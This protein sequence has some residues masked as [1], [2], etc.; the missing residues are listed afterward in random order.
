M[1]I[2]FQCP[3]CA[4]VLKVPDSMAGRKGKC[5]RCGTV[6]T[7]PPAGQIQAEAP[8]PRPAARKSRGADPEVLEPDEMVEEDEEE[9][10]PLARKRA[11]NVAK[12][13]EDDA[14]EAREVRKRSK[15]RGKKKDKKRSPL[16]LYGLLGGFALL[17]FCSA[18][19]V[20]GWWLFA[21]RSVID[22][23]KFMP[24]HCQVLATIHMDELLQSGAFKELRR[25]IPEI[26]QALTQDKNKEMGLAAEDVEKMVIGGSTM[27][28]DET[29]TVVRTKKPVYAPDLRTGMKRT[30][31]TETKIGK[32]LLQEP[33]DSSSPAFC[34]PDKKVVIV[35]KT[36]ALR[37][38]LK[39]DK[40]PV[41]SE[42]LLAA[43]KQVD[44]SKTIA[45]AM[46]ARTGQS[47]PGAPPAAPFLG[48][49]PLLAQGFDKADGLAVQSQFG[50]DV[51]VDITILCR[52]S[53]NAEDLHKLIGLS[54]VGLRKM[55][56]IPREITTLLD[57]SNFK[58]TGNNLLY[59]TTFKVGP[60]IQ[61]YKNQ[62]GKP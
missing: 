8:S 59:S 16:L 27:N 11:S 10:T 3:G 50:S 55:E 44:F 12:D 37:A 25:E 48:A 23:L 51:R 29:I 53:K 52:E 54:L 4:N 57:P 46:D 42:G 15:K 1:T 31:Y 32:Y 41:F 33:A 21:P 49:N 38:V 13:E 5:P 24:D 60:L 43:M 28:P 22:E 40:K 2:A 17:L 9:A 61:A 45:F 19:G 56:G 47:K 35:G 30:T 39:R 20:V 18:A 34:V 14:E 36:E 58:V 6:N 62:K 7:I 26:E